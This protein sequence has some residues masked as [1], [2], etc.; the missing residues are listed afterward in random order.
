MASMGQD[1]SS[2]EIEGV[3]I[4]HPAVQEHGPCI[5]E[6]PGS[7]TGLSLSVQEKLLELTI[8]AQDDLAAAA[9]ER[10]DRRRATWQGGVVRSFAELEE[11]D[12]RGWQTTT[13]SERVLMIW[14]LTWEAM[15]LAGFNGPPPRLQ[16][17]AGGVRRR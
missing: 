13:G 15:L 2:V 12:R 4:H 10:A 17:S 16:R 14:P 9:K 6:R 1:I 5:A 7:T 11:V 8:M 3:L